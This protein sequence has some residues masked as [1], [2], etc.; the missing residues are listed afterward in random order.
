V[1]R[2]V[3]I[4]AASLFPYSAL[5]AW[6]GSSRDARRA[7]QRPKIVPTVRAKASAQGP[8]E[9]DLVRALTHGNQHDG[10]DADATNQP[11]DAGRAAHDSGGGSAST[12][13]FVVARGRDL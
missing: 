8:T 5:G 13:R 4:A 1:P 10:Q 11:R 3:V 9:T 7:G 12:Y 6:I 2:V